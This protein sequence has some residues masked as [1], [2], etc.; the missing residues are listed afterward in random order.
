MADLTI[1]PANVALAGSGASTQIVQAGEA[2]TQGEPLYKSAADDKYYLADANASSA[3]ADVLGIALTPAATDGYLVMQK[4]G[5]INL[6]ATLTANETYVVSATAGGIAPIGDLT[7]GDYTSIIG[8][9]NTTSKLTIDLHK[10][11]VAKP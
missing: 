1:T 4:S 7:T 3:T 8:V 6:G 9:A 10:T 5:P 2:V 11:G